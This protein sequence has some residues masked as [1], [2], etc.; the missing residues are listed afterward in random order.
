MIIA[1]GRC[2]SVT[3]DAHEFK[4]QLQG[5]LTGLATLGNGKEIGEGK[6]R[7]LVSDL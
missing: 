1:D 2:L 5:G 4:L 3:F 7:F 6:G